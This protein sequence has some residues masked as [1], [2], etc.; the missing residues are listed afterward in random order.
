M[1]DIPELFDFDTGRAGTF[2][3]QPD[4]TKLFRGIQRN[5]SWMRQ[6][7]Y[8]VDAGTNHLR[9]LQMGIVDLKNEEWETITP[10]ELDRRL[11]SQLY[12]PP[13]LPTALPPTLPVTHGF[14]TRDNGVGVMQ[15][16]ALAGDRPGVTLR[17][18][19]VER[20]HLE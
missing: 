8:D 14:R 20:A 6:E 13:R 17:Y 18:K 10:A 16:T 12:G 2:P 11:R 3:V 5:D 1:R 4:G 15:I 9:V 7:G 19:L